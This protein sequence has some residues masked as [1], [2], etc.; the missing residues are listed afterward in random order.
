MNSFSKKEWIDLVFEGKNKSYGAYDLRA[1]SGTI[2]LKA[3]FIGVMLALS[4]ISIPVIANYGNTTPVA[5]T[6]PEK[7]DPIKVDFVVPVDAEIFKKDEVPVVKNNEEPAKKIRE[8]SAEDITKYTEPQLT[9]ELTANE[10]VKSVDEL[11]GQK[12]G[13]EDVKGD[14]EGK[15]DAI[16]PGSEAIPGVIDGTETGTGEA[17]GTIFEDFRVDKKAEFPGGI[18]NFMR[19]VQRSYRIPDLERSKQYTVFVSFVVE[20]DGSISN[21]KVLKDPGN[22]LGDEAIRTLKNI[23]TKWEPG[24]YRGKPVRM[25]HYL[26]ITVMLR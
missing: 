6:Q 22:G 15:I 20:V 5:E 17:P 26:P 14:S 24:I 10:E 9:D 19:I 1:Q 11:V 7:K 12:T 18:K 21:I 2:M 3:L 25:L 4:L 8:K 16:N 13:A 23:K